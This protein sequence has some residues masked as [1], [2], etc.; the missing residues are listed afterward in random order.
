VTEMGKGQS[1][2]PAGTVALI[3]RA[4]PALE[5]GEYAITVEQTLGNRNTRPDRRDAID[6]PS[7]PDTKRFAVRGPRVALDPGD[8]VTLFPPANSEGLYHNTLPHVVLA[9]PT[10]PW[11][12]SPGDAYHGTPWL[13]VLLFGDDEPVT[14]RRG[15]LGELGLPVEY[16]EH[17]D[18][19]CDLIETD[20]PLF[21]AIAPSLLDLPWLAHVRRV[22]ADIKPGL[23]QHGDTDF[24]V[25]VGNRLPAPNSRST[26]YLVSLEGH[27]D[28]IQPHPAPATVRLASL[29]SW[30]FTSV[31]DGPTFQDRVKALKPCALQMPYSGSAT[32]D[33]EQDVADAFAMG[34]VAVDHQTRQGDKTVSWYRGPLVPS[35]PCP[36]TPV[37]D[38]SAADALVRYDR[39]TG[40]MDVS[41][42]AAWQL[43]RLLAVQNRAFSIA[44]YNWKRTV[45]QKTARVVE[46]RRIASTLGTVLPLDEGKLRKEGAASVPRA[47]AA[48]LAKTLG[49]ALRANPLVIDA[50]TAAA[51][52]GHQRLRA[53][54]ELASVVNNRAALAAIHEDTTVDSVVEEWLSHLR[55]LEG[56][57]FNYL[58][59]DERALPVESLRFFYV[60]PVWIDSLVHGAYSIGRATSADVN[61]DATL[62]S[63]VHAG[64]QGDVS[65]FLLRSSVV[66]GWPGLEVTAYGSDNLPISTVIRQE[67]IS[68]TVLLFIVAGAIHHVDISEPS[69]GLH[70]GVDLTSPDQLLR[71]ITVPADAPENTQRGDQVA[72]ATKTAGPVPY[73]S[74]STRV[75]DVSTLATKVQDALQ[76]IHANND[77]VDGSRRPFTAAELAV[78]MV[79]G[80]QAVR[81]TL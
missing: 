45:A 71:Y 57:P 63:K 47:A 78:Q 52:P 14:A 4:V 74:S 31:D 61:H 11:M 38:M 77:P 22:C 5:A 12:R 46:F 17:A 25:V 43:G 6:V 33:A 29:A 80:V 18:D 32:T 7:A 36:S 67:R 69:E 54:R 34:Y 8:C 39:G 62:A 49:P 2:V 53:F 28:H 35:A 41:Y 16:G 3:E 72:R 26:A 1:T 20:G 50:R 76:D 73:R 75:I 64:A 19:P 55:A 21:S 60:D 81:F 68:A 58:V 65:G 79:E 48:F 66:S 9:R 40:M 44:L 51:P 70:F 56:V 59:P 10:L 42:A 27:A 37:S 24:A 23:P 15:T 30:R 13:A